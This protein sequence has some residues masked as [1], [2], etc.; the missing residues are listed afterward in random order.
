MV[1]LVLLVAVQTSLASYSLAV[2][3]VEL[4]SAL[5]VVVAGSVVV[6]NSDSQFASEGTTD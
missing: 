2:P 4:A 6:C 1:P 5:A 3:W